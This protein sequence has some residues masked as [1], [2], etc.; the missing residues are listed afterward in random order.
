[1]LLRWLQ[2]PDGWEGH[3]EIGSVGGSNPGGV[4]NIGKAL[5]THSCIAW[6]CHLTELSRAGCKPMTDNVGTCSWQPA[7]Y[8]NIRYISNVSHNLIQTS[9]QRFTRIS[10]NFTR[11]HFAYWHLTFPLGY[12]VYEDPSCVNMSLHCPGFPNW[13]GLTAPPHGSRVIYWR[14]RSVVIITLCTIISNP[15]FLSLV[16][17]YMWSARSHRRG[18]GGHVT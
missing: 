15:P 9:S 16:Q 4:F 12:A 18:R 5:H 11:M 3:S 13:H 7:I 1:M 17:I 2:G 8:I 10:Q 14:Y 6:T